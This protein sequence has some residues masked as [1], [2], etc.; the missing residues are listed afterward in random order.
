MV[1]NDFIF[2]NWGTQSSVRPK[3]WTSAILT[4]M[5][6]IPNSHQWV[7]KH[8]VPLYIDFAAILVHVRF[9]SSSHFG[10]EKKFERCFGFWFEE[11]WPCNFLH[12]SPVLA[13][14]GIDETRCQFQLP[15][16]SKFGSL[17]PSC[18]VISWWW[19]L[20]STNPINLPSGKQ[21]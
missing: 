7:L 14:T 11:I 19:W 16:R 15:R 20:L 17:A 6:T 21:T 3:T 5:W 8:W 4:D 9:C 1:N 18:L 13:V 12:P 2:L 10:D